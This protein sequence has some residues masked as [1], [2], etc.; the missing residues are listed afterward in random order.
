MGTASPGPVMM[1]P[2]R[3]QLTI[4]RVPTGENPIRQGRGHI[5]LSEPPRRK[6]SLLSTVPCEEV[7]SS[8]E[9]GPTL[10]GW[11][12]PRR[13]AHART[14][15]VRHQFLRSHRLASPDRGPHAERLEMGEEPAEVR[16]G[17]PFPSRDGP[18]LVASREAGNGPHEVGDPD[19]TFS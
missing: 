12:P 19:R 1:A 8:S 9:R 13:G 2:I 3:N 14:G 18:P 6:A 16:S 5:V 11:G 17:M 4:R 15:A 10:G 7:V